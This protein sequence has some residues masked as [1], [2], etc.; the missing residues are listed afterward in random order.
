MVQFVTAGREEVALV[1]FTLEGFGGG[2]SH[3]QYLAAFG[4]EPE[5]RAAGH[6]SLLDVLPIGGKGWRGVMDLNAHVSHAAKGE[7]TLI[8]LDAL[9]VSVGDAPNFPSKK[10]KIH[11][12]LEGGRLAEQKLPEG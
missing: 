9:E 12:V 11:I 5:G 10:A 1:L 7:R 8:S 6:Y 4:V 3:T 2:N